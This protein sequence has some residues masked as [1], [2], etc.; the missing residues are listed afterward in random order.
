MKKYWPNNKG[1]LILWIF[2]Y[3]FI[4]TLLVRGSFA[5][6]DPDFGWH[7]QVGAKIAE[8]GTVPD[9]NTYNF[10]YTGNWVDHEWLSNYLIYEIYE[11][12]GYISLTIFF[13]T[14]IL[15]VLVLLNVWARRRFPQLSPYYIIFFQTLGV[16]AASPHFGVRMQEFGVLFLA[17]ILV[18]LDL[19][20]RHRKFAILLLL[21]PI[22]Y[23][24]ACLHGSFLIGFVVFFG[25]IVIKIMEKWLSTHYK[26]DW[27]D[28]SSVLTGKQI[29]KFS[30]I[31]SLAIFVTLFTPY[32]LRLY[33]FLGGY[34]DN[35]YASHIQEWLSQFNYPFQYRQMMYLVLVVL[36]IILYYYYSR[37][38]NRIW[39][40]DLWTLALTGLFILL[41]F[42]SRRHFP[43]LFVSSFYF[44]MLVY[45]EIFRV[46]RTTKPK[47]N[48][49]VWLQ[50]NWINLYLMLCLFLAGILQLSLTN[51]TS[52]PIL[53]FSKDYPVQAVEYLNLHPEFDHDRLFNDYGWGGYLIWASPGRQIFID[54]R[55]P[56]VSYQGHS[57]LEEY[58][59]FFDQH[60]DFQV[61]LD[62]YEIDLVLLPRRDQEIWAKKW[63]QIV[64]SLP[65]RNLAS[66]NYLRTYLSTSQGWRAIYYDRTA[67]IYK[68][69]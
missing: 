32:R 55:L 24:W 64:F 5:Y 17:L 10:T 23:L 48:R 31:G 65:N 25:W 57:F 50:H 67:I 38:K 21:I 9:I 16:I 69:I 27:L 28:F 6:L 30:G 40:I 56:Q 12:I 36:G 13:A 33:S 39:K 51:F 47:E 22:M 7:L 68:R 41:A 4:F 14:I 49:T 20:T 15:T 60:A 46:S 34:R 11:N 35:Y 8:T 43:L 26:K 18:I 37:G 62:D 3:F 59:S 58:F 19:Y 66:F 42:K 61:R 54:G 1:S 63:E 44:L 29:L 2:F 53:S 45:G 52:T